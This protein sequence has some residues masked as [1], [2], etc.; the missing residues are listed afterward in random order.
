MQLPYH[1]EWDI[2]DSSKLDDWLAC[3]RQYFYKHLLGWRITAPAH[4][5]YFGNCW[6]IAREHSLINGYQD[7]EGAYNAFITEY[8]KEFPSDTD[9]LYR[10]KTPAAVLSAL[11]TLNEDFRADLALN[12]VVELD[13]QKMTEI[14][15]TVPVDDKRV[16]YYRMD[17]IME[18]KEDGMIFSWDHKTTSEKYIKGFQWPEQF[19]L[20]IQNGTYT[21][22]LYCMFPI[23]KVLGIEFYGVGF[24]YLSRGSKAR[25][26]GY[27]A[28]FRKV[29]A[30]KTPDQMNSWL[31]N[32][33]R[34][35]DDIDREMQR[36]DE[37]TDDDEVMMCFPMNPK[38][39]TMYRGCA[40]HDFCL[41]WANPLRRCGEPP[42]GFHE[43][44]W[45]P[46]AMETT[47]KKNL[48]WGGEV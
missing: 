35:L 15:G 1:K 45:D 24:V 16:L 41:S 4:D 5:L 2:R 42:L 13:G 40:F 25:P 39:C 31:W 36:L 33:N 20:G 48:E 14:S 7:I 26:P 12:K 37:C 6:H 21:H 10:P 29:S 34:L 30:F 22:C 28:T 18:R 38:S 32:V 8:R 9:E 23:E 47:N 3:P 19:Y 43:E 44:F 27:Y 46:S 11:L 17:S